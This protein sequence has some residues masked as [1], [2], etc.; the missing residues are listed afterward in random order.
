MT[1]FSL[2]GRVALVT[3]G[4]TGLGRSIAEVLAEAGAGVAVVGRRPEPPAQTAAA[5]EA[6]GG[7]ALAVAADV[8]A[9]AA[10]PDV[11]SRVTGWGG[12]LDILVNNAG[13]GTRRA[14][15][16]VDEA[17]WDRLHAVNL[18]A[19]FFM[20]KA[21]LPV[22]IAQGGG[23][24]VNVASTFALGAGPR[25]TPAYSAAKAGLLALTR[26]LAVAHGPQG[27][28]VNAVVPAFIPTDMTRGLWAGLS[29]TER[30]EF[31]RRYPV[32]R[33][34]RPEDIAY[35]V[36]YLA[37]SEASWVSGIALTVDGGQTARGW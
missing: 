2:E 35:A 33:L 4:G 19:A 21:A 11:I 17:E 15:L 31:P 10:L 22:M 36:L 32:G 23:V 16:E 37:S 34:G 12:R 1:P 24:I 25:P 8:T 28:R 6:R 18:K 9:T 13:A 3:G 29:E 27:I 5:I 14:I 7:K 26:S 30:A 20:T